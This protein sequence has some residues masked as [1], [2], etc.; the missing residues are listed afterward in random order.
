LFGWVFGID[1][2]WTE[3][4]AGSDIRIPPV[5]RFIIKYITP[6]MLLTILASW[7]WSEWRKH[8]FLEDIPPADK[9]IIL[10]TR[11]GLLGLFVFLLLMVRIVWRR[12][13][14][15]TVQESEP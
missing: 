12:R 1:R 5:Y 7:V 14:L 4:H 10:L 15:N 8:L 11:L 3:L 6:L 13:S 9:P 2:A